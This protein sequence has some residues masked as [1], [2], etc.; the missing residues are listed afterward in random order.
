MSNKG[1]GITLIY[2]EIYN[3]I[4]IMK[5]TKSLKNEEVLWKKTNRK[6]AAKKYQKDF[7]V[8]LVQ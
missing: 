6:T 3:E 4:D 7:W 1:S 8:C 2:N 5:I